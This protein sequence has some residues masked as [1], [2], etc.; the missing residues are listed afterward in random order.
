MESMEVTQ[1]YDQ[2]ESACSSKVRQCSIKEDLEDPVLEEYRD[3]K[4]G[5]FLLIQFLKL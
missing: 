3:W 1:E 5:T 4:V 2:G